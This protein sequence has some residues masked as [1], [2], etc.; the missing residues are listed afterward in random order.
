MSDERPTLN[1]LCELGVF[2]F[3]GQR[4]QLKSDALGWVLYYNGG[5]LA[6]YATRVGVADDIL[7]DIFGESRGVGEKPVK[8]E[9]YAMTL[10]FSED[11]REVLLI[12]K[13]H[14]EW[15]RGKLNIPGGHVEDGE[16]MVHAAVREL[17]EETGLVI[18]VERLKPLVIMDHPDHHLEAFVGHTDIRG[19]QAMT[20]E[21]LWHADP[22]RLSERV[23]RSVRWW[24]ALAL[25]TSVSLPIVYR[26]L[27]GHEENHDR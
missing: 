27:T 16:E 23:I 12:E 3:A 21:R 19:A 13:N 8:F 17:K 10:I 18:P 9:R 4:W 20:D 22:L 7:Y 25:D 24:V 2:V 5:V 1:A 11:D 6:R 15:Q 14:P 26:D